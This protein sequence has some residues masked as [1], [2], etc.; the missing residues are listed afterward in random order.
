MCQD[1]LINNSW[2]FNV[3]VSIKENFQFIYIINRDMRLFRS[4]LK[5]RNI[6]A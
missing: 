6:Y 4:P 5:L 3:F 2:E 1:S